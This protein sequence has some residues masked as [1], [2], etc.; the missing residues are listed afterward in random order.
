MGV[1]LCFTSAGAEQV[2][3]SGNPLK[4]NFLNRIL[5]ERGWTDL[6]S[7]PLLPGESWSNDSGQ[8]VVNVDWKAPTASVAAL[9][10]HPEKVERTGGLF[11]GGLIALRTLNFQYYHL[12][13]LQGPSPNLSLVV[14]NPGNR[15]ALLY[16]RRGVGK[17]S[18]DYFSTGHTNNT[19]WYEALADNL[20]EF[21]EIP[22]G[23][24]SMIFEQELKPEYV[25]SGTLGLTLV[26]GPPLQF[27]FIARKGQES[28][29][30]NNL[31]KEDDVHSRG[32]YPA[33]YQIL[34]R[35]FTIGD[36]P[37]NMPIGAVRQQT[38]SGVRELRGDYGVFYQLDLTIKNPSD[39]PAKASLLFNPRGGAA[40]G[41]VLLN[42]E[43]IEVPRTEAFAEKHLREFEV[44]ALS[45]VELKIETIPEGASSYPVRMVVK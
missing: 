23:Q 40:T 41:T 10:D 13:K 37:L 20:G 27:A 35:T 7:G 19:Q 3:L 42:D 33:P 9:S 21:I 1:F 11:F 2:W 18:L 28:P 6:P 17:P 34:K 4:T 38:F 39:Q 16:M 26:E 15:D 32:F 29:S 45:S 12:G 30:F 36:P 31:L 5:Q 43:V 44:P 22:A 24:T 25:V 8:T 14:M